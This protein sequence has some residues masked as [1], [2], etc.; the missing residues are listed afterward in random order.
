MS[1]NV[2]HGLL[3]RPQLDQVRALL[4]QGPWLDGRQ[5]AGAE[6]ARIKRNLQLD[7]ASSTQA[8]LAELIKR[9]LH[10]SEPFKQLALPRRISTPLF[11][12][13]DE[14]MEYGL[15]TDDAYRAQEMLRTDL[16]VTLFLS[17]PESYDGGA[18]VLGDSAVKAAA[19]DAVVYPATSIHR[20]ARVERGSRLACVFWVQS[21]VR[22]EA[23]R[24][25]LV[26]LQGISARLSGQHAVSLAL[27]RV[28]QNLLRMWL[29]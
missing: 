21:L 12:R 17:E 3:T 26:A 23:Q 27:S 25:I 14:G 29:D 16:A 18:L 5:T 7:R 1:L 19:G 10:E 2:L 15:H 22:D 20:V 8:E 11:S 24:D 13:Y 9:A 6:A 4:E 28:Q